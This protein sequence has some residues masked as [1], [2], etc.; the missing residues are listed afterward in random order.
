[1]YA[2]VAQEGMF[3]LVGCCPTA[4][5][6]AVFRIFV[7]VMRND[8]SELKTLTSMAECW[9]CARWFDHLSSLKEVLY[10]VPAMSC[11]FQGVSAR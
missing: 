2:E 5:S 4:L 10:P 7:V 9:Q 11:A 3:I 1:M 6:H 8:I